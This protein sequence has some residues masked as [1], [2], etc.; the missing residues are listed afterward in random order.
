MK[1]AMGKLKKKG[2]QC[3]HYNRERGGADG[4]NVLEGKTKMGNPAGRS[5]A[6]QAKSAQKRVPREG[7][8]ETTRINSGRWEE[9]T[10]IRQYEVRPSRFSVLSSGYVGR[11]LVFGQALKNCFYQT[12]A[13]KEPFFAN[14]RHFWDCF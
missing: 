7:F 1:P 2:K 6:G 14:N 11:W 3:F 12:K 5:Q 13:K 8:Y 10:G 4:H 9:L